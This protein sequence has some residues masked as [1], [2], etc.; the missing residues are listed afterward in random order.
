MSRNSK[1][2]EQVRQAVVFDKQHGEQVMKA[3][4]REI[5]PVARLLGEKIA[6]KAVSYAEDAVY[7]ELNRRVPQLRDAVEDAMTQSGAQ[8]YLDK[9]RESVVRAGGEIGETAIAK[10][11]EAGG[12]A[13]ESASSPTELTGEKLRQLGSAAPAER[14]LAKFEYENKKDVTRAQNQS[15]QQKLRGTRRTSETSNSA[16]G[17]RHVNHGR[18]Q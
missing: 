5:E 16:Q 18:E 1:I 8:P 12:K 4:G 15:A 13:I 3:A 7:D 9:A 10:V 11:G 17:H 6:D 14:P 2:N